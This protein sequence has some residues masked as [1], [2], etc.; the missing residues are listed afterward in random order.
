[1]VTVCRLTAI[2][3]PQVALKFFIQMHIECA[4]VVQMLLRIIRSG[5]EKDGAGAWWCYF[6]KG[7]QRGFSDTG[8][9]REWDE[10]RESLPGIKGRVSGKG[11]HLSKDSEAGFVLCCRSGGHGRS[12]SD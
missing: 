11:K 1:M 8:L 6:A 3:R 7:G 2:R 5:R 9:S 10:L 12:G 4:D